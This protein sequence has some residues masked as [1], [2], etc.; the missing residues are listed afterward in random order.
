MWKLFPYLKPYWKA[1]LLAPLLMLM[2]VFMDLLQPK[3][4]A[5]I[6]NEGILKQNPAHIQQT[7]ALMIGAALIGVLGGLGCTVFSSIAAQNF[8]ADLRKSLFDKVQS[9]SFGNLDHF[10]TGSLIT[11]LTNDV[12]QVQNIVLVMLRILVRAPFLAAG[13]LLMVLTISAKLSLILLAVIPILSFSLVYII[14]KGFPIFSEVQ[15]K[16]DSLNAVLQENLAGI[17]VVKAF[18]REN[19]EIKRFGKTNDDLMSITI[20]GSRTMALIM[21]IMMLLMN[22]SIVAILWF[23]GL[24]TWEGSIKLGDLVAFINYVTQVLFSLMIVGMMLMMVSRAKASADRIV[25]VLETTPDVQNPTVAN[26]DPIISGRVVF[27]NVSFAYH[28]GD[29]VLDHI[30][31]TVDPGQT[32]AVLGATG[33]GKSTMVNLIPR[34]YDPTAGR[35]LID[36]IDI[37][38]KDLQTLRKNIGMVL[39]DPILFSGTVKDNISFGN[40]KAPQE[41]IEAAAKAAQAHEFIVKM[42]KGYDTPLGQRGINLSG[43][44]KQRIAIARALLLKPAILIL[45][46][47]TSAVDSATESKIQQSFKE[48][49]QK[50]TGFIIAQRISS[51]LEADKII[52][53]DEGKIVAEGTHQELIQN[54]TIYQD[55]YQSQLGEGERLNV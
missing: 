22:V 24:M 5:S 47:S 12:G 46:D 16:L 45:D 13:S 20:K 8:G 50:T 44:Q 31:L 52:V 42:P 2:E 26:K 18:V 6:I 34:L 38:E 36:G 51:V 7:G 53:M 17:R 19:Y 30:N 9:F 29:L 1:A 15:K 41:E 35:I 37:R 21:P 4:I 43:G 25:E 49:L 3:F 28:T 55:I 32:V 54:S 39:Q 33:S 11:R 14:R 23:G 27:Q 48:L 40:P 10:A